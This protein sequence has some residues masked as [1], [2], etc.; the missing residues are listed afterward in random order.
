MT[1]CSRQRYCDPNKNFVY[2]QDETTLHMYHMYSYTDVLPPPAQEIHDQTMRQLYASNLHEEL[3]FA[4]TQGLRLT[5]HPLC[6][7]ERKIALRFY[8]AD[9]A[10]PATLT[11]AR[12]ARGLRAHLF[13]IAPTR[14]CVC[15]AGFHCSPK[16]ASPAFRRT[17]TLALVL[18][19]GFGLAPFAKGDYGSDHR[20]R[21]WMSCQIVGC[22][23]LRANG[24]MARLTSAPPPVIST[25]TRCEEENSPAPRRTRSDEA[26][27]RDRSSDCDPGPGER[28]LPGSVRSGPVAADLLRIDH[29]RT[30]SAG[31]LCDESRSGTLEAIGL[32]FG[33]MRRQNEF[34]Q[35][36]SGLQGFKSDTPECRRLGGRHGLVEVTFSKTDA[37]ERS[38]GEIRGLERRCRSRRRR[39]C[40]V[41]NA[42]VSLTNPALA[43]RQAME[44]LNATQGRI[45]SR[46][47]DTWGYGFVS[48]GRSADTTAPSRCSPPATRTPRELDDAAERCRETGANFKVEGS[49]RGQRGREH[50]RCDTRG[51][52]S[53]RKTL[54]S[55]SRESR[56]Q[57]GGDNLEERST[58]RVRQDEPAPLRIRQNP[59]FNAKG[60]STRRSS[61]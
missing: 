28:S 36:V 30:P 8:V 9:G 33:Q 25:A 27:H 32:G 41:G 56:T 14:S 7:P 52:D 57:I 4:T 17:S 12:L 45:G 22:R 31:L 10:R 58:G 3:P 24:A 15:K 37:A 34:T 18:T 42:M 38:G 19:S 49:A 6:D 21:A 44:E 55:I 5:L 50:A 47:S 54:A 40:Q 29:L 23:G 46:I 20:L 1:I 11:E 26:H 53:E 51:L 39:Q 13:C 43:L 61:Y 59:I 2:R 16:N 35:G 48:A 60:F